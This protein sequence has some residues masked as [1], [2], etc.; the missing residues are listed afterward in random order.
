[1]KVHLTASVTA[2]PGNSEAMKALLLE[3]VSHSTQEEACLQYELYQS[4]ENE[5]LFIFH[6]TW[7]DQASLDAHDVKD[8]ITAFV[9][10]A[11]PIMDGG[12]QVEKTKRVS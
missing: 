12:I 5:N 1:M 11:S 9:K 8:H 10:N 3:L 4:T 2:T 7:A 6:E